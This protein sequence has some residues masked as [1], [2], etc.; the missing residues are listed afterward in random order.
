MYLYTRMHLPCTQRVLW[1]E[2]LGQ[3]PRP[4]STKR[5]RLL[6]FMASQGLTASD[7]LWELWERLGGS[8]LRVWGCFGARLAML[9]LALELGAAGQHGW[10]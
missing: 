9:E 6:S 5:H 8:G 1:S 10:G 7:W 4:V 3:R 2:E